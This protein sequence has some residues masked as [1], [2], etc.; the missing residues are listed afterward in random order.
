[1]KAWRQKSDWRGGES[2]FGGEMRDPT[3]LSEDYVFPE[4]ERQGGRDA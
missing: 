2:L 1:M 4:V 3:M